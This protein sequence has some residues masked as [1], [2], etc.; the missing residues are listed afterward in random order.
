MKNFCW[1][2]ILLLASVAAATEV[3]TVL[4][5]LRQ[6]ILSS[7]VEGTIEKHNFREGESFR[8][9]DVLV[10]LDDT[11]IK[12][13]L[14]RARSAER[15]A[16]AALDYSRKNLAVANELKT[17]GIQGQQELDRAQFEVAAAEAR[18][19]GAEAALKMAEQELA[20]SR[21]AAPFAGRVVRRM[22]QEH[23]FVRAGQQMLQIIDDHQLLAALHLDSTLRHQVKLG[24]KRQI[25]VDETGT[26][27]TGQIVEISGDVDSGSRTFE[28]KISIDNADG[29][30][31]AGMSGVLLGGN[32]GD[33]S[34]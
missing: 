26:V 24:E 15:E 20:D 25:K 11:M 13:R 10:E 22:A 2:V 9:G 1:L 4:F 3:R 27:H 8:Q 21:L 31:S 28:I 34:K 7:R 23:E 12:L 29:A 5:P 14:L 32:G 16:A 17:K 19:L 18:M 6:S 33:R 30:L